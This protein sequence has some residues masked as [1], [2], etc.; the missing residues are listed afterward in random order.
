MRR[1][2]TIAGN[3]GFIQHGEKFCDIEWFSQVAVRAG[4]DQPLDLAG[5]GIRANNN[6]R[7]VLSRGVGFEFSKHIPAREVRQ[8]QIEQDEIWQMLASQIKSNPPLYRCEQV[9]F[10]TFL[11]YLFDQR[12]VGKI[13]LNVKNGVSISFGA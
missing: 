10:G 3:R 5:G 4:R 1:L 2:H 6:D 12:Q 8:M 11:D 7:N 13:V 9:N